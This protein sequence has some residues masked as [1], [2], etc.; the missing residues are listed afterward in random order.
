MKYN[1]E[2]HQKNCFA[3]K[4]VP[5]KQHRIRFIWWLIG[6]FINQLIHSL[7]DLLTFDLLIYLYVVLHLCISL[8]LIEI[9]LSMV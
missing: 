1:I 6:R 3:L 5:S 9:L 2:L 8:R 4:H 7:I